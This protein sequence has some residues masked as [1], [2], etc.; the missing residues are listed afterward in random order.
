MSPRKSPP[1]PRKRA[2]R[3]PLRGKTGYHG[4]VASEKNLKES[5]THSDDYHSLADGAELSDDQDLTD[6]NDSHD[7]DIART[8]TKD[9]NGRTTCRD[10]AGKFA[11][12]PRR[13]DLSPTLGVHDPKIDLATAL[14]SPM[15]K[16][17]ANGARSPDSPADARSD[18]I[19]SSLR[20]QTA[21]MLHDNGDLQRLVDSL[22]S[23]LN[24]MRKMHETSR[25]ELN[26]ARDLIA[27]LR[28][29]VKTS[30]G[31]WEQIQMA[32][33]LQ[34]EEHSQQIARLKSEN[35]YDKIIRPVSKSDAATDTDFIVEE[36]EKASADKPMYTMYDKS[37]IRMKNSDCEKHEPISPSLGSEPRSL[38]EG[39][40]PDMMTLIEKM[41][42]D[43]EMKL[44]TERERNDEMIK[45]MQNE[46]NSRSLERKL[47]DVHCAIL[48]QT[49]T[50]VS[51]NAAKEIISLPAN[52]AHK[53]KP[54]D[55][56]AGFSFSNEMKIRTWLKLIVDNASSRGGVPAKAMMQGLIQQ[57]TNIV[58]HID[59]LPYEDR[60]S[61][62]AEEAV[63]SESMSHQLHEPTEI[64]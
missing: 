21:R 63:I 9:R 46:A 28:Q 52:H 42:N 55:V 12:D 13:Y 14:A 11:V 35:A 39:N 41:R 56:S 7:A 38:R 30:E 53:L 3:A 40:G 49:R 62:H 64:S 20:D 22:T 5:S 1:K 47:D 4:K 57:A 54:L 15:P 51:K 17:D 37:T 10:A 24:H 33:E 60:E 19:I 6:Q 8:Y 23:D 25:S 27:K 2:D 36:K 48:E 29:R 45:Q 59:S 50:V 43:F 18:K 58:N 16:T 61:Y 44:Q 34:L 26:D 31:Q 32:Y